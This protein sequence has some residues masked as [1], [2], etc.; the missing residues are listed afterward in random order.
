MPANTL[1]PPSDRNP[2]QAKHQNR[3]LAWH[4]KSASAAADVDNAGRHL[5]PTAAEANGLIVFSAPNN[6]VRS[7]ITAAKPPQ[8]ALCNSRAPPG[9]AAKAGL[10][11]NLMVPNISDQPVLPSDQM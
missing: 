7:N 8:T 3:L 10:R 11:L 1:S 6:R 2:K 5:K 9:G 4:R